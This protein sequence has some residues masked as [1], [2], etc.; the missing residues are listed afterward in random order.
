MAL[1]TGCFKEDEMIAPHPRG[2]V[3][4]DT[5][6]MMQDYRNQV[7]FRLDSGIVAG[8]VPKIS[9]DLGFE[10]G[11]SGWKIILNT[12]DF[13]EVADLGV[14]PFGQPT[15]TSGLNWTFD[16][17]DGN[18]DSLAFGN[19][20]RVD[21]GDTISKNHVYIVNRG[22]DAAGNQL[23]YVQL[24]FDSLTNRTYYFRWAGLTGSNPVSAEVLADPSVSYTWYRFS[25]GGIPVNPE[26]VRT[27]FDLLFTQYTTLLF[28]D[29]G[30]AYPYLVTG[31]LL[32]RYL[33][34]AAADSIRAFSEITFETAQTLRF[35]TALDAIGYDWKYYDFETGA[36]TVYTEKNYVIRSVSG[37]YY[38]LR[39]I[40]F[41]N[42][43]GAKGYP[44]IEYQRL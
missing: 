35:S 39:F 8:S 33:V 4:T 17:S 31:V 41:Y 34:E 11:P 28:T 20:F 32:N 27:D 2:D 5:I 40:G 7:Y 22:I 24:I 12:A 29:L 38:K 42:N 10:C 9:T 16:K 13:M 19:W 18:P 43:Q 23:G 14:V 21:Q 36:Y 25:D 3:Q 1:M 26:P 30:E 6:S 44:V 15:D 37:F